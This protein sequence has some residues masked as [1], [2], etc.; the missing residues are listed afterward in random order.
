M[1][2]QEEPRLFSSASLEQAYAVFI[3]SFCHVNGIEELAAKRRVSGK[4][5]TA[6]F[7]SVL[8]EQ[9]LAAEAN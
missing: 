3:A 9:R 5:T 1:N 2:A 4:V 7:K 6:L 8:E